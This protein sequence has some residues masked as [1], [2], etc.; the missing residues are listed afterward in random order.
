MNKSNFLYFF[1]LLMSS[2]V[3]GQINTYTPYSYF[4]YGILEEFGT[5]KNISMGGLGMTILDNNCLNYTN[6]ATYVFLDKTSFELGVKSSFIKMSQNELTQKNFIS[7]LSMIGLGFP[8]SEKIGIAVSLSPYS[9]VGYNLTTT[10]LIVNSENSPIESTYNHSGSGGLNKFL[11]GVAFNARKKEKSHLSLGLNFNYLFGSIQRET[12]IYSNN[13]STYFRDK[14]D[15]IINGLNIELGGVYSTSLEEIGDHILSFGFK[16]QPKSTLKS[17]LNL[18]QATYLGPIYNPLDTLG[19]TIISEEHSLI[20]NDDFPS[21]YSLGFSLQDKD[22]EK[23]LIGVDYNAS[24]GYSSTHLYHNLSEDVIRNKQEY[25]FGGFFIPNKSDIYNYFN[26]IQYRFGV[27]YVSGPLDI[28]NVVGDVS[29]KLK[30]ISFN[31]GLGLP[32][33]KTHSIVNIGLQY[34]VMG[35]NNHVDYIRENYYNLYLSMTL[36][37]KWFNKRKIQ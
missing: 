14:N 16:I 34:G 21:T 8:V 20:N 3:R 24:G 26:R 5:T 1:I 11:F 33:A 6:P 19:T 17:K 18:L 15:K 31:I 4:G 28:G 32:I 29:E 27:S 23:W 36:N 25:I 2:L 13:S 7:R 35:N 22:R 12:T 30:D 9:S 10:D 37:E